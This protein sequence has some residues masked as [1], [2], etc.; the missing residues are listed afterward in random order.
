MG[1]ISKAANWLSELLPMLTPRQTGTT[2]CKL[3]GQIWAITSH[4]LAGFRASPPP[5][6]ATVC[7]FECRSLF[8]AISTPNSIST[9]ASPDRNVK[10]AGCDEQVHAV[11]KPAMTPGISNGLCFNNV[12]CGVQIT[13]F[14][15]QAGAHVM[16]RQ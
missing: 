5:E 1:I 10:S 13:F 3:L 4:E 6:K 2:E 12:T 8:R 9:I 15:I 16:R 7:D 14:K 11:S